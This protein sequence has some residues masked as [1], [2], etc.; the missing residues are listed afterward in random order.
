MSGA[1]EANAKSQGSIYAVM[2]LTIAVII[3]LLMVQ[4][5]SL[6]RTFIV[7]LTAPLGIIGV[8]LFLLITQQPF[9]F[10]H[11]GRYC[12]IGNHHAQRSD[13]AGSN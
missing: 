3:T 10:S 6:Q 4:L 8:T 7:L 2:P 12:P 5:Q 9:G 13:L 11:A 1:Q